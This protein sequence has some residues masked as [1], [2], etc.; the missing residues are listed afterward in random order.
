MKTFICYINFRQIIFHLF[1]AIN[2]L[3][4]KKSFFYT[5]P[6]YV[7]NSRSCSTCQLNQFFVARNCEKLP[8]ND[9]RI[10]PDLK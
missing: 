5:P 2:F 1:F 3:L 8:L 10:T 6:Y 9:N 7:S 4:P